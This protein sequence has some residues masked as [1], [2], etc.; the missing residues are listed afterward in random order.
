MDHS[1]G[2]KRRAK[3]EGAGPRRGQALLAT[4]MGA[5]T[6]YFGRIV[7]ELRAVLGRMM[8]VTRSQV[9]LS[10]AGCYD[11]SETPTLCKGCGRAWAEVF[12]SLPHGGLAGVPIVRNQWAAPVALGGESPL[13]RPES[14]A[15]RRHQLACR[16]IKSSGWHRLWDG[17]RSETSAR[18]ETDQRDSKNRVRGRLP[19]A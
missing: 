5:L 2:K 11:R 19:A 1:G 13:Q 14:L 18:D 6:R 16:R 17:E 15:L 8:D 4:A 3:Q 10:A 7:P 12:R 9:C